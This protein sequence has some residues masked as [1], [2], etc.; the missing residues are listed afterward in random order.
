MNVNAA[1]RFVDFSYVDIRQERNVV[2]L[3]EFVFHLL[4]PRPNCL[5]LQFQMYYREYRTNESLAYLDLS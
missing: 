4:T 3:I 2:M 1:M 5:I